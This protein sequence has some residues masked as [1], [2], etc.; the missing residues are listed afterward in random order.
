MEELYCN[1]L[2]NTIGIVQKQIIRTV[3]VFNESKVDSNI[4]GLLIN[5]LRI[6]HLVLMNVQH[7]SHFI[8]IHIDEQFLLR[9]QTEPTQFSVCTWPAV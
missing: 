9:P 6:K 7:S 3:F 1:P 8:C 5:V 2:L 4:L